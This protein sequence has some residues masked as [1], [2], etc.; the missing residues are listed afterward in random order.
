MERALSA[1]ER[2]LPVAAMISR[3]VRLAAV[4]A[5]V[6]AGVIAVALFRDGLPEPPA[7]ALATV[8]LA[9]ALFLPG[10]VLLLLSGALGQL[11]ELPARLRA[12]PGTGKQH[13]EELGRLVRERGRR[14]G[15]PLRA[16]RLLALGR[17]SRELLTPYAPLAPLLSPPFLAAAAL[18]LLVTP[19]LVAGALAALL[20][21]A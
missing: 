9:V 14:R 5:L 2:V 18:S 11:L 16:W 10:I 8:A 20:R 13:A 3:V 21:L 6:S 15:L 12:L 7:R 19:V 1:L 4:A 17:S